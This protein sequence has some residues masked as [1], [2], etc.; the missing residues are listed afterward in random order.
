MVFK[1]LRCKRAVWNEINREIVERRWANRFLHNSADE[2]KPAPVN[3]ETRFKAR[4]VVSFGITFLVDGQFIEEIQDLRGIDRV[5]LRKEVPAT[6]T[7]T[8]FS[9][10][11]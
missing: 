8:R 7:I 5:S 6:G 4:R 11:R 3:M 9:A 2:M 1:S 10:A